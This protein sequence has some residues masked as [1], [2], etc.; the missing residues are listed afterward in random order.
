MK[1]VDHATLGM[2][3][4]LLCLLGP[5]LFFIRRAKTGALL[6]VRRIS[7]IDAIDEAVGRC[8]EMGRP[9]SYTTAL[10]GVGPVLYACLGI[11]Y[12]ISRRVARYKSRLFLP[13]SAPDV[14][15]ISEEVMRDAYRAE[16]A[17]SAFEPQN[18]RFLSDEQF[19][20]AAGYI[21]LVQ[22]E[23]VA[24]AFLF[25]RFTA[26]SLILAEAGQQVGAMQIAGSVSPEQVP[27]FICTC[28]YTLI[29]EELYA[30]SAYLTREPVQLGSL[31]GQ[32]RSKLVLFLLVVVGVTIA[33]FNAVFPESAIMN[34]DEALL[35][36][37]W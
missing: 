37:F 35:K 1:G 23:K 19:A 9:L 31:Y 20:F 26:E 15:A 29:G 30:A 12:H 32:D 22:R 33:T 10:T 14:M 24:A 4:L 3:I 21:G 7:G 34:V 5:V 8:A 2:L 11:L 16:G 6:P 28:D 18:I 13:Q 25:G 36:A 27:F 17:L